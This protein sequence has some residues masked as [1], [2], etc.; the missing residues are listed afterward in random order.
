MVSNSTIERN[1]NVIDNF[2]SAFSSHNA[3]NMALCYGENIH[4]LDPVFGNL[5]GREVSQ[6]WKML[7]HKSKGNLLISYSDIWADEEYGGAKWV[8]QYQFGNRRVTNT[9]TARFRF[10]EGKIIEHSDHF[11][12]WKWSRQALGITGWFFGWTPFFRRKIRLK[13]RA[14]LEA[15]NKN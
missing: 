14:Q 3:E 5:H 15:F 13:T 7:I 11:N 10:S 8:A 12:L 2:Y 6:M 1:K 9:V 4:F